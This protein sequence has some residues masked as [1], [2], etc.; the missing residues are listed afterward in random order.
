MSESQERGFE[1]DCLH[2]LHFDLSMKFSD[3]SPE[4]APPVMLNTL[5]NS[6]V[7]KSM[8]AGKS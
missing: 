1:A 7:G 6:Q 4:A 2:V 5:H 3:G 8:R